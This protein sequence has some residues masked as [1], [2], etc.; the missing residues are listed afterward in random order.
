VIAIGSRTP[1]HVW[2]RININVLLEFEVLLVNLLGAKFPDV[3]PGV[4]SW[5]SLI[6]TFDFLHFSI[7][8]VEL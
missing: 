6:R 5:A 4:L 2:I 7:G 8:N 1:S 3:F